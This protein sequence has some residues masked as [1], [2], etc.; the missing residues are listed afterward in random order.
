[1]SLVLWSTMQCHSQCPTAMERSG[2]PSDQAFLHPGWSIKWASTP[3]S[4]NPFMGV[5]MKH[6]LQERP[7]CHDCTLLCTVN[8]TADHISHKNAVQFLQGPG[9]GIPPPASSHQSSTNGWNT[10]FQQWNMCT[11]RPPCNLPR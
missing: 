9:H 5:A 1:M 7:T 8:P 10:S 2:T 3:C 4:A 6:L 11:P